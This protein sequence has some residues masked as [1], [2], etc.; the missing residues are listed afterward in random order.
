MILKALYDYYNR[1]ADLAPIGME[2]KEIG[3]LIVIDWN[4]NFVRL[5]DRR[6]DN[7]S[8]S[9]FLVTKQVGRTSGVKPNLLWDNSSYV[10]GYSD[11]EFKGNKLQLCYQ[12]FKDKI[13]EAHQILPENRE[14]TAVYRFYQK[15]YNELLSEIKTDQ[16]WSVVEKNLTKNFSFLID[17]E[18]H[19]VAENSEII[20]AVAK[21]DNKVDNKIYD[22][23][24]CLI[25]GIKSTPV[26]IST[27]TYIPGSQATAKL[28]AF[29]VDSGY[30]SY[31]KSQGNN[32]PISEEANFAF[33]TALKQLL[34]KE[35]KNKFT[36]G[37][38]TYLFWASSKSEASMQ[39][40]NSM[41]SFLGNSFDSDSS[42]TDNPNSKIYEVR[43][44]F[45]KIY[46]GE[47]PS[48]SDDRFYILGLA[49]NSARIAV[50][51]WQDIPIKDF[52]KNLVSHFK[53]MEIIDCR[54]ADKRKPYVGI[55][56][57]MSA[58]TLG[59]DS[60][61]VQPN[62]P[63]AIIKS[64][65]QHTPYPASLFN[66]CIRR[67]RAEQSPSITRIAIIKAYLNRITNNNNNKKLTVMLDN[68]NT[69]QGYVCG[70]LFAVLE[71]IQY[72][73]N[74]Q[75][76]I[77]ERY[78]NAASATPAAVFPTLL[79]LS[80]HHSEKL[81]QGSQIYT[82]KLKAEVIQKISA[83]GFSSH[84]D[85]SDQGRFFVGYYHQRQDIFTS[86][87][88]SSDQETIKI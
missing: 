46:S 32:A 31:G 75:S 25:T 17:G 19:I 41:F 36:L 61:K 21:H 50:V 18:Y 37:S 83:D 77:R 12:S 45:M 47:Y 81:S 7:K 59:G 11:K 44:T 52:A 23:A 9:K 63:D 84:L 38:R 71:Y 57:M 56:S 54:P 85:L 6:I 58:V 15:D 34:G 39:I 1:S 73:A 66:A 29:Q 14:L 30:D 27:A 69:N 24:I 16:L 4:G 74:G 5:E 79:N 42:E 8:C 80:V 48:N 35:S 20:S 65:M 51:Y 64:I 76:S 82:E 3:F 72:R 55:H 70:R 49:P 40:E 13:D 62:L 87:T 33:T 43:D 26:T 86:K 10:L 28:V 68:N 60:S 67:I 53:D 22:Q 78:L 88:D 2:Y